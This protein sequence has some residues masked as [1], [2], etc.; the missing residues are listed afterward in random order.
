MKGRIRVESSRCSGLATLQPTV[1]TMDNVGFR[2]SEESNRAPRSVTEMA[3]HSCFS[4]SIQN[5][6]HLNC[7]IHAFIESNWKTMNCILLRPIRISF[8]QEWN[9]SRLWELSI[10][11][12]AAWKLL[13]FWTLSI[14]RN[15]KPILWIVRKFRGFGGGEYEEDCLL[16]C[17]VVW[18]L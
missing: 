13:A 8:L 6:L 5:T 9:I 11:S 3:L 14:V 15:S 7:K 18:H 12:A 10:K 4:V 1:W 17:Y 16:W 2:T